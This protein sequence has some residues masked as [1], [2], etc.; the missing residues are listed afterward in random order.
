MMEARWT[1]TLGEMCFV[2]EELYDM[3]HFHLNKVEYEKNW[4]KINLKWKWM[5]LVDERNVLLRSSPPPPLFSYLGTP[6]QSW[7]TNQERPTAPRPLDHSGSKK[8]LC[9]L[10]RDN[11]FNFKLIWGYTVCTIKAQWNDMKS[12]SLKTGPET[13]S[14]NNHKLIDT[15]NVG[16]GTPT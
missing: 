1:K 5:D 11:L 16:P 4:Y 2:G 6:H 12:R 9:Q 13:M 15:T 3:L 10:V 8:H 14:Y 7:I